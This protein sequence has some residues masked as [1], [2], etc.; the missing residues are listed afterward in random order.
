[1]VEVVAR[2]RGI[3]APSPSPSYSGGRV[4]ERGRTRRTLFASGVIHEVRWR[5]ARSPLDFLSLFAFARV[6]RFIHPTAL[7]DP[8]LTQP[9]PRVRGRG[10]GSLHFFCEEIW[11]RLGEPYKMTLLADTRTTDAKRPPVSGWA[12]HFALTS[13]QTFRSLSSNKTDVAAS[14]PIAMRDA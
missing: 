5:W 6:R 3:A 8:P 12:F 1:M 10:A 7:P 4:G 9:L 14:P 11:V 13:S 2:T